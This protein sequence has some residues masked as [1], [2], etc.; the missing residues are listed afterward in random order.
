ML[1]A[2][3]IPALKS[4]DPMDSQQVK[5]WK[6]HAPI[7]ETALFSDLGLPEG[8]RTHLESAVALARSVDTVDKMPD[9]GAIIVEL[10]QALHLVRPL[11]PE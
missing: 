10:T 9:H 8:V 5:L 2:P 4:A 1:H 11:V 6:S 7:F 3:P